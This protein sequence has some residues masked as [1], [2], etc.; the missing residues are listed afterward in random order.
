MQGNQMTVGVELAQS[1]WNVARLPSQTLLGRCRDLVVNWNVCLKS[2]GMTDCIVYESVAIYVCS[3]HHHQHS[4]RGGSQVLQK[5]DIEFAKYW[6]IN[7]SIA[8]F[9][10]D[11][12]CDVKR[13]TGVA[14]QQ[15]ET[16]FHLLGGGDLTLPII[17]L[18][19][20]R[21]SLIE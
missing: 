4:A 8:N 20:C 5:Q 9:F 1:S 12:R 11:C 2:F 18:L 16:S 15:S 10:V 19:L 7:L 3:V 6:H 17:W 13:S 21:Q 14:Q